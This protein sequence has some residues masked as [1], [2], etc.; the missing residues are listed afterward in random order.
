MLDSESTQEFGWHGGFGAEV[1]AG[2]HF[3]IHGD[4]RYTFLSWN[5][6]TTSR[7]SPGSRFLPKYKGSMWTAG[8][9]LYF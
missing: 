1:R 7:T 6:E 2:K 4:Y 8:L 3:G 5:N 9:T